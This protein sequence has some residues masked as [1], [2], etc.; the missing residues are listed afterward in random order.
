MLFTAYDCFTLACSS[1]PCFVLAS[2]AITHILVSG[3]PCGLASILRITHDVEEAVFLSQRIYVL[4]VHPGRVKR[5]IWVDL[6]NG[7]T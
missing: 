2:G 5:E 3:I 1:A 6:L 7:F 4:T